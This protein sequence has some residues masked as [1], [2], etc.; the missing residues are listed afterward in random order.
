MISKDQQGRNEYSI[1]GGETGKNRL[2]V[3]TRTLEVQTGSFI[4]QSGIKDGFKCL[5]LGCG[6]GEVSFYISNLV[7]SA[8]SVTGMDVDVSQLNFA[9]D[10]KQQRGVL[11]SDFICRD[12][13]QLT[14][15][16]EYDLVYSRF[17]LSHLSNASLALEAIFKALKPGGILLL[18]DTDFSGHFCYPENQNFTDYVRWYQQLLKQRGANANRGQELHFMLKRAGF[19]NVEFSIHQPIHVEG[20]GKQMAEITLAAIRDS[21]IEEKIAVSDAIDR[22]INGLIQLRTQR[23]SLI[24]MPRIF[25]F[26]AYRPA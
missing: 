15:F 11:N 7:G 8:G 9:R 1:Q 24:S 26:K 21:L 22:C 6:A 25:Q 17:L 3:L 12:V 23:D 4:S 19:E 2:S 5:D 14:E 16:E 18:E 20:E 10:S 13:Y